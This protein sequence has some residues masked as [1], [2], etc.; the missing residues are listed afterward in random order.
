MYLAFAGEI[1]TTKALFLPPIFRCNLCLFWPLHPRITRDEP[2]FRDQRQFAMKVVRFAEIF[3]ARWVE[4]T[5]ISAKEG[6]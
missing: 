3:L 5:V 1:L 6:R 2:L 4:K